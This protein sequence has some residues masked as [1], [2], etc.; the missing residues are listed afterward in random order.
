MTQD[1]A[2]AIAFA[3]SDP[4]TVLIVTQSDPYY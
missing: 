3:A 4:D 2:A 1:T